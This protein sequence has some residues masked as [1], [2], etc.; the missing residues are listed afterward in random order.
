MIVINTAEVSI[1][2]CI[3]LSSI[4]R[5]MRIDDSHQVDTAVVSTS[6]DSAVF[7]TISRGYLDCIDDYHQYSRGI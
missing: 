5:G 7:M 3:C 1:L 2:D 4:Q 6:S